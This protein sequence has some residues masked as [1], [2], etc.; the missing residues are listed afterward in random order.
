MILSDELQNKIKR[1]F[2]KDTATRERLLA[3]DAETIREIGSISQK[4]INPEDVVVAIESNDS[5]T[6]KCLYN[7]SKKLIELQELYKEL[8]YEFYKKTEHYNRQS[9]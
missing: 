7:Q 3:G 4:G 9:K 2:A 5:E 6:I 8:C 1:L